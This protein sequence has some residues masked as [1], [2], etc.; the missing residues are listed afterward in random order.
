MSDEEASKARRS[1]R[2]PNR[3]VDGWRI[4][5]L[6]G[7]FLEL[8]GPT[9]DDRYSEFV[10]V[11][12]HARVPRAFTLLARSPDEEFELTLQF[13]V[14]A[15]EFRLPLALCTAGD[16]SLPAALD[17]LRKAHPIDFWLRQAVEMLTQFHHV[18]ETLVKATVQE[19]AWGEAGET[20]LDLLQRA[21][22]GEDT[23]AWRL[24][25]ALAMKRA[26]PDLE[27]AQEEARGAGL[28]KPRRR[29]RITDE[30][31]AEVTQVYGDADAQG[32]P[33]TQ[34]VADH[35]QTSHSTAARWVGL[36]RRAGKIPQ[37]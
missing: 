5:A 30:H 14:N 8:G 23:E 13:V 31:L 33:P 34:A 10:P 21:D 29:N 11:G 37:R 9:T 7:L 25:A 18:I 26:M 20:G 27:A 32:R 4:K 15:G 3:V 36:A 2:T 22:L 35:F 24:H 16:V 17:R 12:E 1:I 19:V 28:R 6:P